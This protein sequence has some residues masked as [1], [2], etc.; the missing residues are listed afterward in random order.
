MF[1]LAFPISL[2][3]VLINYSHPLL[4]SFTRSG[5]YTGRIADR[6]HGHFG[7]GSTSN[8]EEKCNCQEVTISRD[9][10]ECFGNLLG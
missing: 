7:T 5:G 4:Y 9:V 6:R 10:R 1:F 8:G 3:G 2:F